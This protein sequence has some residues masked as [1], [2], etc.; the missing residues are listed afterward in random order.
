MITSKTLLFISHPPLFTAPALAPR[1]VDARNWRTALQPQS[2]KALG[3][4]SA[5]WALSEF[6]EE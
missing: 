6:A 2:L 1:D 5:Q 3:W 4:S